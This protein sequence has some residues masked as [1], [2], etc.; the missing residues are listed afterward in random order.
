[1]IEVCR[2]NASLVRQNV[3][4]ALPIPDPSMKRKLRRA[5]TCIYCVFAAHH[6]VHKTPRFFASQPPDLMRA[7]SDFIGSDSF[8]T[9]LWWCV[10]VRV[11]VFG[12]SMIRSQ[13]RFIVQDEIWRVELPIWIKKSWQNWPPHLKNTKPRNEKQVFLINPRK[14][15]TFCND[16]MASYQKVFSKFYAHDLAAYTDSKLDQYLENQRCEL[17]SI[18]VVIENS[19]NLPECFIQR[20]R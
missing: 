13:T 3:Q 7:V 4:R 8:R 15:S 16:I 12:G 14:S 1:M 10:A 5:N 19:Q 18:I 6:I 11:F 20:L 2:W 17:E 9:S